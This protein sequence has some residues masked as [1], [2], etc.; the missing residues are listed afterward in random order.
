MILH[1]GQKT[2]QVKVLLDT[3]C[4]IALINQETVE[5]WGIKKKEHQTPRSIENYT[6]ESVLGAG[7]FYTETMCLQHR[8]HYT[9][10][11]FE[12]SPMDPEINIFLPF[13]WITK[14]PPQGAWTMKEIR[15]NS[16]AFLE[17]CTKWET[18]NFTL[19]WDET[20]CTDPSALLIGYVSSTEPSNEVPPEFQQFLGIMSKEAADA[21]PAHRP[22]DC[23]I[24]LVE[25]GTVPWGPIYPL[26]EDELQV[27]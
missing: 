13:S 3:G 7:R 22:Y 5:K 23:K 27:L 1:H 26:S 21:L 19:T 8:K 15:F 11:N 17:K 24:D 10:G 4:A 25:G 2:H 18:K 6:G 9:K 20:I 14:H 12:I 16:A